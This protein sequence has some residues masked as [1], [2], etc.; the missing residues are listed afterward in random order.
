MTRLFDERLGEEVHR[1]ALDD[2]LPFY[3]IPRPAFRQKYAVIATRYGSCDA[4]FHAPGRDGPWRPPH[5]VAHFLEHELFEDEAGT[6]FDAFS[7]IGASP[8]A[9]T[10]YDQTAYHFGCVES[11]EPALDLLLGFVGKASFTDASADRERR[12]IAQEI[13]MYEDSPGWQTMHALREALFVRHPVRI[14]ICGT[15]AT[16]D[17]ITAEQLDLC[18]RTFYRPDNMVLVVAGDL[19]PAD[20]LDRARARWA[21]ARPDA[22][23]GGGE[24][25]RR[26][27]P[28]EP[29]EVVHPERRLTLDVAAPRVLMGFKDRAPGD[30]GEA[31]LRRELEMS[32]LLDQIFGPASRFHDEHYRAGLI[33]ATF[34]TGYAADRDY[35][36]AVIGG[37]TERPDD[38]VDAVRRAIAQARE[39]GVDP[40]D[41]ARVRNKAVGR[42]VRLWNDVDRAADA[43]VTA[44]FLGIDLFRFIEV[45]ESI[46]AESL[47]RRLREHLAESLGVVVH[48]EPSGR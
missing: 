38:L 39:R 35:G 14:D 21:E 1:G 44:H 42:W 25:L 40:D 6:V 29:P 7:K 20:V 33:D 24:P 45:L 8:N 32:L 43:Q 23:A 36:Y 22:P 15:V 5:G 2:G 18:Y 34:S 10:S 11:F 27:A 26:I 16:I 17:E 37:E 12:V 9:Y 13:K 47:D 30:E 41:I 46:D 3:V 48:V 31:L 28:D 4:E 19:D